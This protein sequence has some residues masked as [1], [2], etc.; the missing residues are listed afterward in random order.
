MN[1][2]CLKEKLV[3]RFDGKTD[4]TL[5]D[6]IRYPL[7]SWP[8]T[9]VSYRVDFSAEP[10]RAADLSLFLDG[11]QI[12]F[13]FSNTVC[14]EDGLLLCADVCFITDLPSGEKRVFRLEKAKPAEFQSGFAVSYEEARVTVSTP[15][16]GVK[17]PVSRKNPVGPEGPVAAVKGPGG[18]AG[19]SCFH[20]AGRRLEEI[21]TTRTE[22]GPVFE[23]WRVKYRLEGG[24]VHTADIKLF[25]GLDFFTLDEETFGIDTDEGLFWRFDWDGFNP[26]HRFAPNNPGELPYD[27]AYA[28]EDYPWQKID[29]PY[30]ESF[31]HPMD[32]PTAGEGGELPFRLNVFEVQNANAR[33]KCA[34]FW[35]ERS[36]ESAGLFIR[37]S[38][39]WDNGRYD[40]FTSFDGTAVRY[41]YDGI[42]RW[43]FPVSGGTRG[44]GISYYRHEKDKQ[45]FLNTIR[46]LKG[47]EGFPVPRLGLHGVGYTSFLENW[48]NTLSLDKVKDYVL[49]YP[50]DGKRPEKICSR[51]ALKSPEEMLDHLFSYMLVPSLPL[52][53]ASVNGGFSGV[54]YRRVSDLYFPAYNLFYDRFGDADRERAEAVLLLLLYLAQ[55]ECCMPMFVMHGGPPN[56]L[57][58]VKRC[59]GNA[60]CL[61]PEHPDHELFV[62]TFEKFIPLTA[63]FMTRPPLERYMLRGGRWAESVGTYVWA[64][65]RHALDAHAAARLLGNRPNTACCRETAMLGQWLVHSMTAPFNGENPET[66]ALLSKNRRYWGT[67]FAAGEKRRRLHPP[68][69]A[70]AARRMPPNTLWQ[71]A[72]ALERYD[73]LTAEN[74]RYVS[75]YDDT[76]AEEKR[77]RSALYDAL[78]TCEQRDGGTRPD[79]R[80]CAF[81]GYGV[82]LRSAVGTD[83]EISVHLQQIDGGPNY[84]WGT[85]GMGG[86]GAVY[87]YAGGKAYSHNGSEDI[88]DAM[89]HDCDA[90]C[91]F[92]VWKGYKYRCVGPNILTNGYYDM[93]DFQFAQIDAEAGPDSY[94]RPEY[95]SR[96]VTLSHSDYIL[97]YDAVGAPTVK[98]R[99]SWSVALYDEFPDIYMLTPVKDRCELRTPECKTLWYHG[100]G[101]SA[102][103]VTHRKGLSAQ[104]AGGLCAVRHEGLWT[105]Y[106]F[107]ARKPVAITRDGIDFAGKAAAVRVDDGGSYSLALF[108]GGLLRYGGITIETPGEKPAAVS[109]YDRREHTFEGRVTALRD[110]LIRIDCENGGRVLYIDG[111]AASQDEDGFVAV[112]QGSHT[113]SL[114]QTGFLPVPGKPVIEHI[115]TGSGRAEIRWRPVNSAAS[116]AVDISLDGGHSWRAAAESAGNSCRIEGLENEIKAHFRVTA[117]NAEHSGEPSHEYP[118][119]VSRA[120]PVPPDGLAIRIREGALDF[121]WGEISGAREYALYEKRRGGELRPVYRGPE[122]EYTYRKTEPA[123]SEYAVAAVNLNGEGA[124]SGFID[125][126]PDSLANWRPPKGAF[127][128]NS[129]YNHHPFYAFNIHQFKPSPEPYPA[130]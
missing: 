42:L 36:G 77:D 124:L 80:S 50:K 9:P 29:E 102:A 117:K 21:M 12:P 89:L 113:L 76:E 40:I 53:G 108:D 88:G 130:E 26:T 49:T 61:F 14:R 97:I 62:Q 45:V 54:P 98:T 63:L 87:Y 44:L 91:M 34:A 33:N 39:G 99:F 82:I 112:R 64:Y 59:L 73:P 79:F 90:G 122:R 52:Y 129:L 19:S 103:L 30:V 32:L 126:N 67:C 51:S 104:Y 74:L 55:G 96:S 65:L 68:Q 20:A 72:L 43:R 38:E 5:E 46:A 1:K 47:F 28:Y 118:A 70:H 78:F 109:L 10:V 125:D 17:L 120:L 23:R 24:A 110:A 128:R 58:D 4:F 92:G 48:H 8:P 85:A 105:D 106:I 41:F 71:L 25:A 94:A 13:Q 127:D 2:P 60:A 93:G 111:E 57:S 6:R 101:D 100:S 116:Y 83:D 75:R 69:G 15:H 86:N 3:Y 7:F 114:T 121:S 31:T 16:A 18:W 123:I 37:N 27:P 66:F 11:V 84:R 35:D 22:S 95:Q 115:A 107:R 81:T 56:L 119:A